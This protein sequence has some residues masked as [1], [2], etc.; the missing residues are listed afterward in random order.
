MKAVNLVKL[1]RY[2]LPLEEAI[3]G[4]QEPLIR[5]GGRDDVK[6]YF[7]HYKNKDP[8]FL[9]VSQLMMRVREE[10]HNIILIITSYSDL[11]NQE[12]VNQ[13][14]KQT[15][16]DLCMKV[17]EEMVKLYSFMGKPFEKYSKKK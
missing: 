13:F 9:I 2:N 7:I 10:E 4:F 17:S 16:I 15:I 11:R 5:L 8:Y 1:G 12:I 6:K 3:K 14:E